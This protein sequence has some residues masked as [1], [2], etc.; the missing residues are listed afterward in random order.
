MLKKSKKRVQG[1]YITPSQVQKLSEK[2]IISATMNPDGSWTV[3]KIAKA[4]HERI[5]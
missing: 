3:T 5:H 4:H 2:A 1:V